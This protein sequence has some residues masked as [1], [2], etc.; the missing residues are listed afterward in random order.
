MIAAAEAAQ[1][2]MEALRKLAK[3][4]QAPKG[5][6]VW[7]YEEQIGI[8]IPF[9]ITADAIA[10]YSELVGKYGKQA[11]DRYTEPSSHLDY[12]ASVKFH[13]EFKLDGKTFE[14]VNVV[15]MQLTFDEYFSATQAEGLSFKKERVV[16]LDGEGKV[17]HISGDGPTEVPIL[18]I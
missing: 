15:T 18:A 8:R 11:F 16:I 14:K 9:A 3:E 6:K 17:L 10:Y 13:Q 4:G 5:E 1:P 12:H 2:S 7:W